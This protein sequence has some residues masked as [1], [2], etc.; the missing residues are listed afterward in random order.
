M[1]SGKD[2]VLL[3]ISLLLWSRFPATWLSA[4]RARYP[5]GGL[6][7][8]SHLSLAQCRRLQRSMLH[9]TAMDARWEVDITEPESEAGRL[10]PD[11]LAK[12]IEI[13]KE[14]GF[15][16]LRGASLFSDQQLRDAQARVEGELKR[17]EQKTEALDILDRAP[18]L[19]RAEWGKG[20]LRKLFWFEEAGSTAPRC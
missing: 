15:V 5:R 20:E 9:G 19:P 7:S 18:W 4:P 14:Q 17:I 13:L 12:V 8:G 2:L 10:S 1:A 3:L 16:I 11:S 6:C